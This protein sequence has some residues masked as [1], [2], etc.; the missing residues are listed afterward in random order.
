MLY[1]IEYKVNDEGDWVKYNNVK[2]EDFN[3]AEDVFLDAKE[4]FPSYRFRIN[5]GGDKLWFL[6][7]IDYSHPS[8][9]MYWYNLDNKYY[10][11]MEDAEEAAELYEK[12]HPGEVVEVC[13]IEVE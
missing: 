12:E 2:Y 9:K 1:K 7:I 3:E 6:R 5:S 10:S 13:W 4:Q 11:V 8:G